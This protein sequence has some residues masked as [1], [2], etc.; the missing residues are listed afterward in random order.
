MA[1]NR[2]RSTTPSA[3]RR[4]P[5]IYSARRRE[6]ITSAGSGITLRSHH[7]AGRDQRNSTAAVALAGPRLGRQFRAHLSRTRRQGAFL[8]GCLPAIYPE[9]LGSRDF[10]GVH[11]VR[12]PYIVGEMANGIATAA[13]VIAAARA[14]VL[15][16]FGAAG[17][18]PARVDGAIGRDPARGWR[19][20]G[21]IQPDS[22]P[23]RTGSRGRDRRALSAARRA[24]GVGVRLHGAVA[25][26][27]A[28]RAARAAPRRGRP[29]STAHARVRENLASG[30]GASV[31]G[32]GAGGD[33]RGAAAR[34]ARS[35]TRRRGWRRSL[36]SP[37]TSPSKPT[38]AAT[39]TTVH[40][41]HCCRLSWACAT[42]LPRV[43]VTRDPSASAR[44]AA[45]GRLARSLARSRSAPPT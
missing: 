21:R 45:S 19:R 22:L 16:F 18:S 42:R 20:R 6:T 41:P 3:D 24:A 37:K 34:R 29:D 33:D 4:W 8:W 7:A 27:G 26:R 23:Q 14:G 35:P 32:A 5:R 12:F 2:S 25:A 10:C 1:P 40:S 43:T 11:N 39:P 44:P 30:S 36:P 9:W 38:R 13:M 15:G 31:H 28:L 17:L